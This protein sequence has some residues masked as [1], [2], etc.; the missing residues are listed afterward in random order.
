MNSPLIYKR[1]GLNFFNIKMTKKSKITNSPAKRLRKEV[2]Q[3]TLRKRQNKGRGV[4]LAARP[5][6]AGLFALPR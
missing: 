6:R 5:L 2:F 3:P 4:S 1:K